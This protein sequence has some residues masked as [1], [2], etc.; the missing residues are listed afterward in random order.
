MGLRKTAKEEKGQAGTNEQVVNAFGEYLESVYVPVDIRPEALTILREFAAA[1][2]PVPL[3]ETTL[4][5]IRTFE[6][7]HKSSTPAVRVQPTA[8]GNQIRKAIQGRRYAHIYF[9]E[10]RKSIKAPK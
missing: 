4:Q 3:A 10:F 7:D 5:E 6:R 9:R 8:T 2:D 1:I